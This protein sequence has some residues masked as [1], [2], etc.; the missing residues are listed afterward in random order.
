MADPNPSEEKKSF[1][2]PL[3]IKCE[4][5]ALKI[6]H[7]LGGC[8][9][10]VYLAYRYHCFGKRTSCWP[11]NQTIVRM[12]GYSERMIIY[13]RKKLVEHNWLTFIRWRAFGLGEYSLAPITAANNAE[14]SASDA[15]PA[16]DCT[17]LQLVAPPPATD[18][19]QGLQPVATK[20]P[21]ESNKKN[22]VGATPNGDPDPER[23]RQGPAK[24]RTGPPPEEAQQVEAIMANWKRN[25]TDGRQPA[26]PPGPSPNRPI[27]QL[28]EFPAR[29]PEADAELERA[30]A[31]LFALP[32]SEADG[33]PKQSVVE[34]EIAA[35]MAER[36]KPRERSS[37]AERSR[38]RRSSQ[39]RTPRR[40]RSSGSSSTVNPVGSL[41][42]L[43]AAAAPTNDSHPQAC[44]HAP[45]QA[46][47][48]SALRPRRP[49][50]SSR[51]DPCRDSANRSRRTPVEGVGGPMK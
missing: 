30:R 16:T 18:C 48:A 3:F 11:S 33:A 23:R 22:A 9:F 8:A 14:A 27:S 1:D 2:A 42:G 26:P 50:T 37:T 39:R 20:S 38:K 5:V 34:A 12:T 25:P 51:G 13:A 31:E 41:S 32:E 10:A 29:N 21:N 36:A 24:G 4:P 7:E 49:R 17:P 40:S 6:A 35:E 28:P 45:P 46:R 44:G 19:A 43:A 47:R 15:T